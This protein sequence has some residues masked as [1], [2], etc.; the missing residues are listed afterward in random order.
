MSVL[1]LVEKCF[2]Q[3]EVISIV[4]YSIQIYTHMSEEINLN[5][6]KISKN[7]KYS[8]IPLIQK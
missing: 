4:C 1:M 5:C 2:Q 3:C 7:H 8:N 6:A